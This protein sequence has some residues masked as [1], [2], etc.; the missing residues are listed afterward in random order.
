MPLTLSI[1]KPPACAECGVEAVNHR[2][3]KFNIFVEQLLAPIHGTI[4]FFGRPIQPIIDGVFDKFSPMAVQIV[5]AIGL[6]AMV[7]AP[8]EYTTESERALWEEAIKRGIS[9]QEFRLLGLPRHIFYATHQ[10]STLI[11]EKVPLP[12]RNMKSI[13][14][15]DDKAKTKARFQKKGFP[16]AK[17]ELCKNLNQALNR[18]RTLAKPVVVKPHIGSGTRHT[19]VHIETE[20]QLIKAYKSATLVSPWAVVEEELVGPVYRATMIDRKLAAVLRRD[21]AHVVGDGVHTIHKLVAEENKNPLRHGPVFAAIIMPNDID[22][23]QIPNAGERVMLHWKVNWGVGGT[24]RDAS[25]E[26]HP[27]NKK[28]F[29]DIAE[30]LDDVFVGIDFMITDISKSWR[31]TP[32][33]GVLEC[34]SMP[35]IGN[36]HYPYT[37]PVRNV[38]G[39]VWDLA[40]PG[41]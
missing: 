7:S 12:T 10:G 20:E 11:F 6:G 2:V 33:C 21:P 14:W 16:V 28:L 15:M 35:F 37:G 4:G 38:A 17:G 23:K 30:Y 24:S 25:D 3:E 26:V 22:S 29:E 9:M 40:F 39:I 18:F 19:T 36:H 32:H 1:R 27:D 5:V 41:S 13:A 31:D 8:D 34:N